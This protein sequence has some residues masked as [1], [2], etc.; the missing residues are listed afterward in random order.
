MMV[1]YSFKSRFEPRIRAGLKLPGFEQYP[2]KLQTIRSPRHNQSRHVRPGEELQ[3]YFNQRHP[4]GYLIGRAYCVTRSEIML[5]FGHRRGMANL[6]YGCDVGPHG[7]LSAR[8]ELD[9]FAVMD[10]FFHW[11]DMEEFWAKEHPGVDEFSG[12]LIRWRPLP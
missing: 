6:V 7:V 2:P 8:E 11:A 10:G 12:V 3:L 1:A 4:G 9:A 5:K